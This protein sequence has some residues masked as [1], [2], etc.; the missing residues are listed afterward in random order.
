MIRNRKK[1]MNSVKEMGK[2]CF[3]GFPKL[4]RH[5]SALHLKR[6]SCIFLQLFIDQLT[7]TSTEHAH[8]HC[9]SQLSLSMHA[10]SQKHTYT[11]EKCTHLKY[12]ATYVP[13]TALTPDPKLT[14][15]VSLT[16][17][18]PISEQ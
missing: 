15:V 17:R 3:V 12:F 8:S 1:K 18:Y 9:R 4:L 6:D 2:C 5:Q 10:Y 11:T 7:L 14:V 13:V 16:V